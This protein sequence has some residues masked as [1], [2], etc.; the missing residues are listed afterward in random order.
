MKPWEIFGLC[1]GVAAFCTALPLLLGWSRD[2]LWLVGG[3]LLLTGALALLVLPLPH[4]AGYVDCGSIV[5]PR[6]AWTGPE[7]C[8]DGSDCTAPDFGPQCAQNR[9]ER[10]HSAALIAVGALGV[11]VLCGRRVLREWRQS[12]DPVD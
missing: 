7:I 11:T 10:I 1:L 8:S 5:H 9:T 3:L 2:R 4:P 6:N 12:P